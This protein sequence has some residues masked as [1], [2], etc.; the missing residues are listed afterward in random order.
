MDF[1]ATADLHLTTETPQSRE[2]GYTKQILSKFEQILR[3]TKN[4]TNSNLLVVAGDFFDSPHPSH[5]P[6]SLTT[7]II[8][9]I[10][11]H[12][13]TIFVVPGQ[14]DLRYHQKG[15]KNTP[16]GTLQAAGVV[17]ILSEHEKTYHDI[18]PEYS[19]I[20]KGWNS[21][22]KINDG[23]VLIMHQMIIKNKLWKTQENGITGQQILKKY[24]NFSYIISGDNHLPH[25][26]KQNN[27]FQLNC[28]S[29][30]RKNKTQID[31]H[32]C[33]WKVNLEEKKITKIKLKIKP[34]EVVF[35]FGKIEQKEK[36][37][38]RKKQALEKIPKFIEKLFDGNK[39]SPKF[40]LILKQIVDETKPSI[41]VKI[42]I[43]DTMERISK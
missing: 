20:G 33:V 12:N 13:V 32:P 16:L 19:F 3:I 15:L 39:T 25:L 43:N 34:K 36:E 26:I 6:Y 5:V 37:D 28:G 4:K 24:P 35:N 41:P 2:D 10:N 40:P 30:P 7:K 22:L 9:I 23:D 38:E 1:I 14:H 18:M 29:I 21:T 31:Y 42:I 8:E 17:T 27:R 11:N